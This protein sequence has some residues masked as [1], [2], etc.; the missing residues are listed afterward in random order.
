MRAASDATGH[1]V[2]ILAD[3]QGPKIRLGCFRGGSAILESGSL[4]TMTSETESLENTDRGRQGT[5]IRATTSNRT[6]ATDV[7]PGDT[8]LIDDGMVKLCALSSD[9]HEVCFRVIEGGVVSD[10]KGD[11][12]ARSPRSTPRP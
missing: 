9:G 11:Q 7:C 4:F 10:R 3:L 5:S 1:R 8:L 12:L 6:L 2:G